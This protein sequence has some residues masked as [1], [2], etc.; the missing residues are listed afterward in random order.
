LLSMLKHVN[1]GQFNPG[2]IMCRKEDQSRTAPV[3]RNIP[4]RLITWNCPSISGIARGS[5]VFWFRPL[6]FVWPLGEH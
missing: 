3:P 6:C 4:P 2:S 1:I 5:V